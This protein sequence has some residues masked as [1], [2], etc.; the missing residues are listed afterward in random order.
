MFINFHAL[1]AFDGQ[2]DISNIAKYRKYH[3]STAERNK[4]QDR[5]VNGWR[6]VGCCW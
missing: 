6:L 1:P 4:N 2:I 5:K 3:C